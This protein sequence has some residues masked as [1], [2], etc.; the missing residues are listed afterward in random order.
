MFKVHFSIP[1]TNWNEIMLDRWTEDNYEWT[2]FDFYWLAQSILFASLSSLSLL[3]SPLLG[4]TRRIANFS[5]DIVDSEVYDKL[6]QQIAPS[7]AGVAPIG[8][9]QVR[10]RVLW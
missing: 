1:L 9:V 5:S 3:F 7:D 2:S 8:P 10:H 4:S 6:L